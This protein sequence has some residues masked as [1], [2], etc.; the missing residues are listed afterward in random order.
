[1]TVKLSNMLFLPFSTVLVINCDHRAVTGV[2][3][4]ASF[5]KNDWKGDNIVGTSEET[6]NV[7]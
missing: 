7:P 6:F 5:V 4:D 1:M 3:C 2:T